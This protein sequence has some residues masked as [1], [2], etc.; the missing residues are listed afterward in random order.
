[1]P[2]HPDAVS[3]ALDHM[4]K[5]LDRQDKEIKEIKDDV[6]EMKGLLSK[7]D[8]KMEAGRMSAVIFRWILGVLIGIF[9]LVGYFN[10]KPNYEQSNPRYQ[11]QQSRQ[12]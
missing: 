6:K 1:M 2:I 8:N 5:R 3:Y 11:E 7:I 9:S 4:E 10:L 12:P